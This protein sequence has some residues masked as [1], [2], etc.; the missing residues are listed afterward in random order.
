MTASNTSKSTAPHILTLGTTVV[1]LRPRQFFLRKITPVSLEL[2]AGWAPY[3]FWTFSKRGK[4][5]VSA[6]IRNP[7]RPVGSLV[8]IPTVQIQNP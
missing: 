5:L 6:G 1:K 2:E 4:F 3:P 7:D 8:A